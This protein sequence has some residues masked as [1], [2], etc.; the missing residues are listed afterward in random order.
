MTADN[1]KIIDAW[2]PC[3]A[4]DEACG[5][6]TGSGRNE[7]AIFTWFASRPIAQARAAVA[8]A[9]LPD[10]PDTRLLIDAAI[11][12]DHGAIGKLADGVN[13]LFPD[14]RPVVLDV[15]SGRG[16]IPLEAA[17]IG[18]TAVGLDLSPVATLA[19]RILADYPLRDWSS[20]PQLPWLRPHQGGL[21]FQTEGRPRLIADLEVFLAEVGRRMRTA[22]EPHYPR[23]PDGSFPWGYLW[24]ISIPCD[25]CGRRFPGSS[26]L[27]GIRSCSTAMG[28]PGF[29][30]DGDLLSDE[31]VAGR[32]GVRLYPRTRRS[33]LNARIVPA[34]QHHGL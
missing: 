10:Q 7:K 19:G 22:M 17:R 8:T 12:G 32:L 26:Q 34:R 20:E 16:I 2:F 31:P 30:T 18:A 24:A 6:P 13:A 15:F 14:G 1:R 21:L 33:W 28:Q 5:N 9:L 29:V 11:E 23:N 27:T 4:V 25:G 3:A